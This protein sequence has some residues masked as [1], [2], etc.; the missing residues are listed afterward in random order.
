MKRIKWLLVIILIGLIPLLIR[1]LLY[2]FIYSKK[3]SLPFSLNEIDF[4]FLGLIINY[5]NIIEMNN[6]GISDKFLGDT[7]VKENNWFG[8]SNLICLFSIMIFLSVLALSLLNRYYADF[9]FK[10]DLELLKN[11]SI[12]LNIISIAFRLTIIDRLTNIENQFLI[13]SRMKN[14]K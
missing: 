5:T 11:F 2:L 4:V 12:A 8:I 10:L 3:S 14:I 6:V 9:S 7:I 13:T 1:F